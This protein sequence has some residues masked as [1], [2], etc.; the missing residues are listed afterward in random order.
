MRKRLS[1]VA[2][3][4][5]GLRPYWLRYKWLDR[6]DVLLCVQWHFDKNIRYCQSYS[7]PE[8]MVTKMYWANL[9]LV[10]TRKNY[11]ENEPENFGSSYG[12]W[13]SIGNVCKRSNL[14]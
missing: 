1:T 12:Y 8:Y 5:G 11:Y 3:M 7:F 4:H 9:G 10:I 2:G 14:N 6:L 13:G